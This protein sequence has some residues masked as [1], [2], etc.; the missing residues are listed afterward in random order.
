[1]LLWPGAQ[2]AWKGAI[3]GGLACANLTNVCPERWRSVVGEI[4][5]KEACTRRVIRR[6]TQQRTYLLVRREAALVH[7]VL[8]FHVFKSRHDKCRCAFAEPLNYFCAVRAIRDVRLG[9]ARC[10][11]GVTD[12]A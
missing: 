11:N 3:T 7:T 9:A 8:L 4:L 2:E 10:A 1:M 6:M 5:S 12:W